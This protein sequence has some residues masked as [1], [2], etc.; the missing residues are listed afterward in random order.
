MA[1]RN[2]HR[3]IPGGGSTWRHFSGVRREQEKRKKTKNGVDISMKTAAK[4]PLACCHKQL[5]PFCLW[6]HG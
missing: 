3:K 6:V 2:T 5:Y 4:T 1:E